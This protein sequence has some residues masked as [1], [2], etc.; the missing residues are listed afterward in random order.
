MA[1]PDILNQKASYRAETATAYNKE[2]DKK[3]N[4][5]KTEIHQEDTEQEKN[6]EK[7]EV[8]TRTQEDIENLKILS[9][10]KMVQEAIYDNNVTQSQYQFTQ[11]E[12]YTNT[13]FNDKT[14]TYIN[15]NTS[16]RYIKYNIDGAWTLYNQL[17]EGN[18]FK[19]DTP[20]KVFETITK[21][22]VELWYN[23]KENEEGNLE[24][25]DIQNDQDI[26]YVI[27]FFQS[28]TENKVQ[29]ASKKDFRVWPKTL[30]A[31]LDDTNTL[32]YTTKTK[33]TE[34]KS[35]TK[36]DE[37]I[38][39]DK[40][41]TTNSGKEDDKIVLPNENTN[42]ED[43]ENFE[44]TGINNN[45]RIHL[46][47]V[48]LPDNNEE[49]IN[50]NYTEKDKETAKIL[51]ETYRKEL[52]TE[53]H[54]I[55]EQEE[56]T[57]KS[58]T[59][60]K[61]KKTIYDAISEDDIWERMINNP[62][63]FEMTYNHDVQKLEMKINT[64]EN[65]L[66]VYKNAKKDTKEWNATSG[67][68]NNF[69][70]NISEIKNKETAK[71]TPDEI[72]VEIEE[73]IQDTPNWTILTPQEKNKVKNIFEQI[74][75]TEDSKEREKII[76]NIEIKRIIQ[77]IKQ[78]I[79]QKRIMDYTNKNRIHIRNI[80]KKQEEKIIEEG[81]SVE[82][83]KAI[84][85]TYKIVAWY[86]IEP[87]TFSLK[88]V[89][90]WETFTYDQNEKKPQIERIEKINFFVLKNNTEKFWIIGFDI[91]GKLLSQEIENNEKTYTISQ[92]DTKIYITEKS[93]EEPVV[94]NTQTEEIIF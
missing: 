86:I 41:I 16:F 40:K 30:S 91:N 11:Q 6:K 22:C 34:T 70:Y 59:T 78:V 38:W 60:Y 21:R 20:K 25:F 1:T 80:I 19:T 85:E 76:H 77:W 55:K 62:K 18:N 50:E 73:R 89:E 10:A 90:T 82:T 32:K 5:E 2:I 12:K 74:N 45:L 17:W 3:I 87:K 36:D 58:Y 88:K 65:I 46:H 48:K 4:K 94:D 44:E 67:N 83:I 7:E 8:I 81:E 27:G 69:T 71:K 84:Q 28:I 49:I 13:D 29:N 92:K 57:I 66:S 61:E 37:W 72:F 24:S 75:K 68:I 53:I 39:T 79:I 14:D 64:Y 93:K 26:L 51:F 47:Q 23:K 31:L 15:M 52:E 54:D 33:E 43:I 56:Q 9:V 35:V 63:T 42:K